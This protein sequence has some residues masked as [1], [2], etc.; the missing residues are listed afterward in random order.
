MQISHNILWFINTNIFLGGWIFFKETTYVKIQRQWQLCKTFSNHRTYTLGVW[1]E[2]KQS[3]KTCMPLIGFPSLWLW[4]ESAAEHY[5]ISLCRTGKS[6]CSSSSFFFSFY[7]QKVCWSSQSLPGPD[8][9]LKLRQRSSSSSDRAGNFIFY[10]F[11]FQFKSAFTVPHE[12]YNF[13]RMKQSE[14]VN[15][16]LKGFMCRGHTV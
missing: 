16:W 2:A 8:F 11:F 5:D 15:D 9:H 12:V 13:D 6:F 14:D 1:E 7:W 10:W 4:S 3:E